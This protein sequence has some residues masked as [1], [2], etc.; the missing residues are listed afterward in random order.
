MKELFMAARSFILSMSSTGCWKKTRGTMS[1]RLSLSV[2]VSA[3][4]RREHP[5]LWRLPERPPDPR[6]AVQ[7]LGDAFAGA[8]GAH[9]VL[10]RLSLLDRDT[11]NTSAPP[12]EL[13]GLWATLRPP[14]HTPPESNWHS[15]LHTQLKVNVGVRE[16]LNSS[17]GDITL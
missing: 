4:D 14:P 17:V 2:N 16:S 1:L 12:W 5:H 11:W 9:G 6:R 8:H 7:S 10:W 3:A 15:L 13:A